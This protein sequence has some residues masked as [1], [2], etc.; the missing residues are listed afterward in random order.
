MS[1]RFSWLGCAIGGL[2]VLA[3]LF[4][5]LAVTGASLSQLRT[6]GQ[7]SLCGTLSPTETLRPVGTATRATSTPDS[8][9][10]DCF[11]GNPYGSQIVHWAK[12]MADT[13][14][15]DPACG[16]KRGG[17]HCNATHYTS[18]FPEPV[19]AYGQSWCQPHNSCADWANGNYQCVSFVRGAYSQV[20]P[21]KLTNDAF[22][23][24]ATYEN[25]P[26]W[27]EIP[28]AAAPDPLQRGLPTPGDVMIFKDMR[29]GHVAIVMDVTPPN[30]GANGWIDFANA[31][32]SSAYDRMPL[33]PNLLVDTREW[34]STYTVWGYL[35]P[36]INASQSLTRL[37]QL[38]SQQY[39]S[40]VEYT[41][42]AS[43][44]CSA[45]AMAEVFNAYGLRLRVHDVLQV[46]STLH[47]I[48]P[49]QG[50]VQ[51]A[52]IAETATQFGFSTTWGEHW[53][54]DQVLSNANAGSPVIVS[55][56]PDR[57]TGGHIVVV[58]GG[59]STNVSIADS[60]SWNRHVVTRQ[61][62]QQWWAGFA[63]IVVPG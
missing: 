12:T 23:L 58:T 42:W 1:S 47:D 24:W 45:A 51:D 48:T 54:L 16:S 37:S 9:S 7:N 63:A 62:F 5:M 39:N 43:S 40:T 29:V 60:S 44:A 2:V 41:T 38:D 3:I 59:D 34:G 8:R 32:S 55:W 21:M 28:A 30:N 19:I 10:S 31:N 15:V 46:E 17:P 25:Q 6:T 14:Y 61:Q 53:T 57:Y 35:R 13:L 33:M 20:Y 52:G 4:G 49:L 36:R 56:P 26:G 18:A 11:P 50:L 22:N 27:Q